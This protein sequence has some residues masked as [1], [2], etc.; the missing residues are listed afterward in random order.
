MICGT[1]DDVPSFSVR[2]GERARFWYRCLY[3]VAIAVMGDDW[4]IEFEE[5]NGKTWFENFYVGTVDIISATTT[6]TYSRDVD[7]NIE[8]LPTTYYDGQG[9]IVRKSL[10]VR[11]AKD[12]AGARVCFNEDTTAAQNIKDFFELWDIPYRPVL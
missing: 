2:R 6:W 9:F 10:G 11:S 4:Q 5:V 12:L 1:Y 3:A 8:F 7:W